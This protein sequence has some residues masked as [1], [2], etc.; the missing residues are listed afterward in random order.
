MEAFPVI[1]YGGACATYTPWV[2]G[3]IQALKQSPKVNN[4]HLPY[5]AILL[6]V[7]LAIAMLAVAGKIAWTS[8]GFAFDPIATFKAL[9]EGTFG[10]AAAPAAYNLQ[11]ALPVKILPPGPDNYGQKPTPTPLPL[12]AKKATL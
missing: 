11:K 8:Q 10:A 12:P 9:V 2:V 1:D 4:R 3:M 6:G 7:I 5:Y